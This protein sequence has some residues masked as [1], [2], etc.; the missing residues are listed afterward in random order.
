M[1]KI[2]FFTF[3][4]IAIHSTA[5]GGPMFFPVESGKVILSKGCMPGEPIKWSGEF[6][7][8]LNGLKPGDKVRLINAGAATQT[9]AL[10]DVV[11][12]AGE[13]GGNYVS[14]SISGA[15]N[16]IGVVGIFAETRSSKFQTAVFTTRAVAPEVCKKMREYSD[17]IS[18]RKLDPDC[19]IL[20]VDGKT[21]K[22][23]I[24]VTTHNW[25]QENDTPTSKTYLRNVFS[26]KLK[27][28][29]IELSGTPK[30]LL[31]VEEKGGKLR[32]LWGAFSG[33]KGPS[34]ISFKEMIVDTKQPAS[35]ESEYQ[36]GGQPCGN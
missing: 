26:D 34:D 22:A 10:G 28:E 18:F 25:L 11:C 29:W 4:F 15:G 19:S 20:W 31:A 9:A 30:P 16:L 36:S 3:A 13:C 23:Q 12:F 1:A 33:I 14:I 21:A 35:I 17:H 27:G 5:F 7:K 24:E 8:E 32:I 6:E 2:A